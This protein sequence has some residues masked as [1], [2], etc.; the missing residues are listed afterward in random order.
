MIITENHYKLIVNRSRTMMC[1]IMTS[2]YNLRLRNMESEITNK[3]NDILAQITK[4][5][6]LLVS[7][8][9][10]PYRTLIFLD[11]PISLIH[12]SSAG[13]SYNV[14]TSSHL[15]STYWTTQN[16]LKNK[17][18]KKALHQHLKSIDCL[19]KETHCLL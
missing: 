1:C 5:L 7:S 6:L 13:V 18:P 8:S 14:I 11:Y 3:W 16:P 15:S 12:L 17:T 10:R 2:L 4:T 19:S 9:A